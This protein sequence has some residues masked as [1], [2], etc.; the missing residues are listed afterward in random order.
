LVCDLVQLRPLPAIVSWIT[1]APAMPRRSS[2]GDIVITARTGLKAV[3]LGGAAV[4]LSA[5]AGTAWAQDAAPAATTSVEEVVVTAQRRAQ[6]LEEVPAAVTA[7]SAEQVR[8][9]GVT[10]FMD[11]AQ[12]ASG[13]Q[14]QKGGYTTQTAI[15]GITSLTT[16]VGFENNVAVYVDGFYQ[17]DSVAMNGDLVN[18]SQVEILK[19]PQGTLY[20][21]NATGGAILINTREPSS[22][23]GGQV[24][25]SYARFNDR[26]LQ[27]YVTG[28]VGDVAAFSIAGSWR[29][30][31]G[32]IKD[33]GTDGRGT[34]G[35]DSVPAKNDS[36]RA[37]LRIQPTDWAK[38][39]FGYNYAKVLDAVGLAYTIYDHALPS[40]PAPPLRATQPDT[41]TNNGRPDNQ[42]VLNEGTIKTELATGLG[43]LTLRTS[44][45]RRKTRVYYDFDG[46]KAQVFAGVV[47]STQDTFQ[48]AADYVINVVPNLD[49]L[50]GGLYFYDK[51]NFTGQQA[52]SGGALTTTDFTALKGKAFAG[53]VDAT[54]HLGKLSLTGGLRYSHEH[55]Y[56]SYYQIARAP[57]PP[58]RNSANFSGV[59]PRLVA[60]YEIAPRTNVYA[61]FSKGFRSGVFQNQPSLT[62]DLVVPI[63][64]EKITAY[65]VGFKTAQANFR[66]DAAAFYYDYSQLQ[67]GVTITNPITNVGVISTIINA[68]A[69]EV[70]GADAQLTWTPVHDLNVSA[71][72]ALIHAR[73]TDFKT[74]T[75]TGFNAATGLNAGNQLQNWSDHQMARAPSVS[76]TL[77]VDYGFDLAGGRMVLAANGSYTSSYVVSNP[78]LYGPL[79][80]AA[81]ADEQ[82]YRQSRYAIANVQAAWTDPGQH[83]TLTVFVNNVTNTRYKLVS[84]G[85][86]F[87]DYRQYNQPRSAG[88]RVGYTF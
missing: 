28:P 85:G 30:S 42:A 9:S 37:K 86:A 57:V 52:Y 80:G 8:K 77:Q 53:Y 62:P 88:V 1:I 6:K 50:V 54:Y 19:G 68:P 82:R 3:L 63:E 64:P 23:F 58:A 16:G 41:V 26:A 81:L 11:I 29:R 84:S 44:F 49:L 46:S 39:T 87:G 38:V 74:A 24:Q 47:P 45:G 35:Y 60:K 18:I 5:V 22:T 69:A 17:P 76:A 78:A 33:L 79:A 20:G 15:R 31:D 2:G 12:L 83:Y 36:I 14:I 48:Q 13:V 70:Y 71:G 25:A 67:V 56:V 10:K 59:T 21:R 40:L 73:Y 55:K 34:N 66:F 7:V 4:A 51:V 65:E 72:V 27:G 43:D 75:G 61:S 32:Y